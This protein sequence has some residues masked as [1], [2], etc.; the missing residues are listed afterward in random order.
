MG[1]IVIVSGSPSSLSRSERILYYLGDLAM[2]E[3]FSVHHVSVKDF[4]AEDLL[5]ANFNSSKIKEISVELQKADGVIVGSPVYKASYSG[6]LKALFDLLPQDVLQDTFVLPVM[7][8]GSSSHLLALD[9]ALKPLL[10]TVKAH[11]LKGLYFQDS[12]ISKTGSEV[13]IDNVMLNRTKKQLNYF[14]RKISVDVPVISEK[15]V[16]SASHY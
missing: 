6:V 16:V 12:E 4:D 5:F 15:D 2:Q 13:I 10:A 11:S 1:R 8:G 3:G 9:Y 7:T 14:M